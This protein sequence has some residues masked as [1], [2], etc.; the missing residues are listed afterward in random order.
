MDRSNTKDKLRWNMLFSFKTSDGGRN[1]GKQQKQYFLEII[2]KSKSLS[3]AIS[4]EGKRLQGG[5]PRRIN[6][7]QLQSH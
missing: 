3:F 1:S 5:Q 4:Q 2:D 7:P 6:E